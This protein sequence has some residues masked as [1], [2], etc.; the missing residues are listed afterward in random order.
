VTDVQASLQDA[1]GTR[2]EVQGEVGRGGMATVFRALDRHLGR[3]VAVKVLHPELKHLLGSDR[4]RREIGIAATLQHPNIVPVYESGEG[5]GLLFYTMALVDGETLRA[6]LERETQLPL[7]EALRIVADVAEALRCAHEHGIVH[8]DVKPENILLTAGRAVVTDFGVARAIAEAGEDRLTTAGMV[9][10]TPAYMSPEQ[11]GGVARPDARMDIYALGCVLYEMLGGEPP[12]TGPSAQAVLARQITEP[13]RSLHVIRA[14]VSPA[15][16]GVVERALAKAP[17]D[18]FATAAEFVAALEHARRAPGWGGRKRRRAALV[19]ASV[20]AVTVAAALLWPRPQRLDPLKIV[21]FPLMDARG[22]DAPGNGEDLAQLISSAMEQS[23]PLRV[24]FGWTWLTPDQR[25]NAALLTAADARRIARAQG[26]RYYLDGSISQLGDSVRLALRLYDAVGDSL[27][28]QRSAA[29]LV[30]GSGLTH[31]ALT[32]VARLLPRLLPAERGFD[33]SLL[34]NLDPSA[35]SNWLLG[36]RFFRRSRYDSA[37]V[38]Y[39]RAVALD[40]G[41]TYAALRGAQAADWANDTALALTLVN[42]A[43]RTGHRLPVRYQEFAL[44]FRF[45]LTGDA[46]SAA[47]HLRRAVAGDTGWAG[48]WMELGEVYYHLLP[49]DADG[50]ETARAAF[51]R[52]HRLAPEFSPALLHLTEIAIR[53]G[54]LERA[55]SFL[56]GYRAVHA[57]SEEQA[58]LEFMLACARRGPQGMHWDAAARAHPAALLQAGK[59]SAVALSLPACSEAELRAVVRLNP[60]DA[61]LKGLRWGAVLVLQALLV[62]EGRM[63]SARAVLNREYARGVS[64]VL[65]VYVADAGLGVG[66]DSG[67]AH[68]TVAVERKWPL[69]VMPARFLRDVG[70]WAWRRGDRAQLDSIVTVLGARLPTRD[71]SDSVVYAGMAGRKALLGGDTV[72]AIER[73]R[74]VRALGTGGELAWAFPGPAGEERLLLARLLLA[75]RQY[76]EAA[77]VAEVFDHQEPMAFLAYVP[78]SLEIRAAS[79]RGMGEG[80][81]AA[82][83]EARLA[84]IARASKQEAQEP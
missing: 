80:Q 51:E 22:R 3:A 31:L 34:E 58:Q 38:F 61:S 77:K 42:V 63:A 81:A 2:Y 32:T 65:G 66:T 14:T 64:G 70:L 41:F 79:A 19:S 82:G 72:T 50:G 59:A 25:G 49:A 54:E 57:D 5:A 52:A 44:G 71:P 6:R 39:Q 43:L 53:S 9:V 56:A 28:D 18:R 68:A 27:L 10:G 74:L 36:E 83:F 40:S 20:L 84:A 4:F 16:Q 8:R 23:E 1:L 33:L 60:D 47:S 62:G 7:D 21:V 17:A 35:L 78:A 75:R 24:V 67:A 48:A 26:A 73:L 13:P 11:A 55:E 45:F 69:S 76:S 29:G 12:F 37:E 15:L 46:D 30:S